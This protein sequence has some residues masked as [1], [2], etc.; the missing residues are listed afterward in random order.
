M[1]KRYGNLFHQIVSLANLRAA[2][3]AA[4][5]GK[6]FYREVKW[7]NGR[8]ERLLRRLRKNLVGGR[9]TTS[10]YTV[11][12][13]QESGK[14]RVIHKLPYYPDRV[15]HHAI[16]RVCNPI[17]EASLIRDTF[18]S[19]P[20]RGISDARRRVSRVINRDQP[21]YALQLDIEQFYPSVRPAM[22]KAAV[23]RKIKCPATL[24]LLDDI[25]DSQDGL[26]LGNYT[27]QIFG[28]LVLSPLDWQV[29]QELGVRGYFRYCDD[30]VLL[31]DDQAY[32]KA[33]QTK[34]ESALE[35]K[36]LALK[37]EKRWVDFGAGHGL[38]FCGYVFRPGSVRVRPHILNSYRK[39]V[40]SRRPMTAARRSSLAAYWGWVR[41][42]TGRRSIGS[43]RQWG[44]P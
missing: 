18:Q 21:R 12:R 27:S 4:R 31:G 19:I 35:R 25:I 26:P 1:P 5:R 28:N 23:R 40:R 8:E 22:T 7:V 16:C 24:A 20:G 44:Q 2:H 9:F 30:L 13:R 42:V 10:S 37:P 36:G 3:H 33:C 38:D 32:L 14:I 17:W 6:G 15:V 34:I 39:T 11:E 43:Q 29:K 41:P